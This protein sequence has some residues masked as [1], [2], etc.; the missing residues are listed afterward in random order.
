MLE[1]LI[2]RQ[3]DTR[4]TKSS[5]CALFY[6]TKCAQMRILAKCPLYKPFFGKTARLTPAV[7]RSITAGRPT[8]LGQRST[9]STLA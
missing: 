1:A 6:W 4:E 5:I 3:K 7:Y 2:F 9:S 8:V